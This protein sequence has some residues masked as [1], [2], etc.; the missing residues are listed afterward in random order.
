MSLAPAIDLTLSLQALGH[1]VN[2]EWVRPTTNTGDWCW[3]LMVG[4]T[5]ISDATV[6]D[7]I[8]H[9]A[10]SLGAWYAA[11]PTV[12]ATQYIE[13][14]EQRRAIF[15]TN[16]QPLYMSLC[17]VTSVLSDVG[18]VKSVTAPRST[19]ITGSATPTLSEEVR[20][21]MPMFSPKRV[22]ADAMETALGS[23][24][25]MI[26]KKDFVVRTEP[27]VGIPQMLTISCTKPDNPV[28][29]R[30]LGDM[31]TVASRLQASEGM[32]THIRVSWE[33]TLS[34][35]RDAIDVIMQ[36]YRYKVE[37]LVLALNMA[38]VNDPPN[39][40]HPERDRRKDYDNGV[41]IMGVT[42]DMLGES[43]DRRDGTSIFMGGMIVSIFYELNYSFQMNSAV[44]SS[45]DTD[46]DPPIPG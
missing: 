19:T 20:K 33:S 43:V 4:T 26:V 46:F 2:A 15:G 35:H 14:W 45:V 7:Y 13:N 41:T 24:P 21:A 36:A 12:T 25:G 3:L 6:D 34:D 5:P 44:P 29:S 31:A 32:L 28:I 9:S 22:V 30:Y 27:T 1:G 10:G 8:A 11:N 18:S 40:Q 38:Q 39:P 42:T 23:L 37:E 17:A 16:D